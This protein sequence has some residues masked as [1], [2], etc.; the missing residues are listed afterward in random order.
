MYR[1]VTIQRRII[2]AHVKKNTDVDM[3]ASWIEGVLPPY[4]PINFV[5]IRRMEQNKPENPIP[6]NAFPYWSIEINQTRCLGPKIPPK[7]FIIPS[8]SS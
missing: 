2:N 1:K 5:I 4:S 6:I 7:P 8:K 3:V